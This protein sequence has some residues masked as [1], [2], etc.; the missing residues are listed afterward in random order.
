VNIHVIIIHNSA[1]VKNPKSINY[2]M[3]KQNE[4]CVRVLYIYIYIYIL[5]YYSEMGRNK[6]LTH[7]VTWMKLKDII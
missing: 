2:E 3:D 7:V 5:E 1:K 4:V 6:L